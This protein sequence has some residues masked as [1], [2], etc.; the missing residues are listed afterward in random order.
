MMLSLL[1]FLA[2]SCS[3][4]ILSVLFAYFLGNLISK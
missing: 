3:V 2:G 4:Y 1:Y